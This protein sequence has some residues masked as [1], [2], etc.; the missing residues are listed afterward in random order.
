MKNL[1]LDKSWQKE[2]YK[3][4]VNKA[5]HRYTPELNIELPISDTLNTFEYLGR[6][7]IF[8]DEL[9]E[10]TGELSRRKFGI[11]PK[12]KANLL[13]G[14]DKNLLVE[15]GKL[16]KL[17]QQIKN[18]DSKPIPWD[19]ILTHT[20]KARDLIWE[21]RSE[22]YNAQEEDKKKNKPKD[23]GA[24]RSN[25][26]YLFN[27]ELYAISELQREIDFFSERAGSKSARLSNF[28]ILSLEGES[29]IGKTHLLCDLVKIRFEK[30]Y[31]TILLFG[32]DF[33]KGLDIWSQIAL[34]L[35]L[36]V[37]ST[38]RQIL[39]LLDKAGNIAD[40]RSI[41]MIDA[42]NETAY[43]KFWKDNLKSFIKEIE[44]YKNIALV[45]SV[46]TGFE[47]EVYTKE[48]KNTLISIEH[49]GFT[50][51]EW[52]AV[53]KFFEEYKIPLPEIPILTPEFQRPLFLRLFCEG[54]GKRLNKKKRQSFRGHEGATFIFETF[55]KF[56]SDKIAK[57]FG[58]PKGKNSKNEYVIWDTVIEKI[59]EVMVRKKFNKDLISPHEIKRIIKNAHPTVDPEKMLQSLE[60]N[61]LIT[62]IPVYI[63]NAK[64]KY[65]YRFPFQKFSDHLIVRYL[66]KR[67]SPKDK[68]FK[69]HFNKKGV[70]GQLVNTYNRGLIEALSIQLPEW[71]N[72]E[73]LFELMDWAKNSYLIKE[74]FIESL[75]WRI[76]DRF[77]VNKK[78]SPKKALR[79]I[80]KYILSNKQDFY[81]LLNAIITV[82]PNPAHPLNALSLNRFLSS[83]G[84]KKRDAWWSTF[85]HDENG[86]RGAVERI[87]EW[88][89]TASRYQQLDRE[90]VKLASI[91]LSWFLSTPDRFI[92]DKATK[93]L[94]S[95]L[96]NRLDT[97]SSLLKLFK[98]ID[99]FYISERL[100][101]VAYGCALRCSDSSNDDLKNL[102]I[103]IYNELFKSGNPPPHL[104]LRDY[105]SGVIREA[106]R[107]GIKL[108]ITI[109]KINPPYKSDPPDSAPSMERLKRK[110]YPKDFNWDKSDQKGKGIVGI[111]RSLMYASDGGLADFGNYELG[112]AISKWSSRRLSQPRLK[113]YQEKRNDFEKGLNSAQAKLYKEFDRLKFLS[114]RIDFWDYKKDKKKGAIVPDK[115]VEKL[116]KKVSD[117]FYKSLSASQLKKFKELENSPRTT[118]YDRFDPKLAERWIAN[119]IL[120]EWYDPMLHGEFDANVQGSR[121]R[122]APKVERIG[123]KYQWMG[124]QELLA[125]I[126]DNYQF[127]GSG[128]NDE[129]T[130]YRGVWQTWER[131]IDPST[132]LRGETQKIPQRNR[133]WD[134]VIYKIGEDNSQNKKWLKDSNGLPRLENI[135]Q[136]KDTQKKEWLNLSGFIEW[137]QEVPPEADSYNNPR[138]RLHYILRSFIVKSEDKKSFIEWLGKQK[139]FYNDTLPPSIDLQEVFLKEYPYGEAF[140]SGYGKDS[141]EDW[142]KDSRFNPLPVSV[143][144]TDAQY[145]TGISSNDGSTGDGARVSLPCRWLY[146]KMDLRNGEE[147][148]KFVDKT[149]NLIFQDP[150]LGTNAHTV[151]LVNKKIFLRFLKDNGYDIVWTLLGEKQIFGTRNST[152]YMSITGV[153]Y[154]NK[155]SLVSRIRISR[156]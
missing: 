86:E 1:L 67:Y 8:Y 81:K 96:T 15:V 109:D 112:S 29:G 136:V 140:K 74:S 80:N 49:E 144:P 3:A 131:D 88:A 69:K 63:P 130:E 105:S 71:T 100:Y 19:K 143:L 4:I 147:E 2:H 54:V 28:P 91:T 98:D 13:K 85:L 79:Y 106:L 45:L 40:T 34:Q 73:E 16:E 39:D 121:D 75:I 6:T 123:K 142:T 102:A 11:V 95:L 72:G 53:V 122:G 68:D 155:A 154:Y 124:M 150:A 66:L 21:L 77:A 87:I 70:F 90:S 58:L 156:R 22:I 51:R 132:I 120:T 36:P 118:K 104:L 103:Q 61:T 9:R 148:S 46:R 134:T 33:Q 93:A 24:I 10:H 149:G 141:T 30:N 62:K 116:F 110:F 32:Q 44:K 12:E 43:P 14:K 7:K 47:K 113:S 83:L 117:A 82:S 135:I 50:F 17:L 78:N 76:P 37:G 94:V 18:Y 145:S 55:T 97:V 48:I 59:A 65:A 101:A 137:E 146:E 107:R 152:G 27:S 139:D 108:N 20:D 151:L 125:R 127:K 89:W 128:W 42:L 126:A 115:N 119:K 64:N 133:W 153:S 52:E 56:A 92:R 25:Q 60:R 138:K 5:G 99:G 111:W 57:E 84:M 23:D 38:A 114:I 31:P 26:S 41:I 35:R 129:I